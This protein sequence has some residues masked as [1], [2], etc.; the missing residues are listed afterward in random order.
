MGKLRYTVG[1]FFI[2][3][4]MTTVFMP[5]QLIVPFPG[6]V[7]PYY[8]NPVL[9]EDTPIPELMINLS[10]E[11]GLPVDVFIAHDPQLEGP[12]HFV[13]K[14]P[15][16]NDSAIE[17]LPYILN[18]PRHL[19]EGTI[20]TLFQS[21]LQLV[22]HHETGSTTFTD[23]GAKIAN[24]SHPAMAA[25][26]VGLRTALN[27][28]YATDAESR[29]IVPYLTPLFQ[30]FLDDYDSTQFRNKA[31]IHQLAAF[32]AS[33]AVAKCRCI[34][35]AK[36]QL[37]LPALNMN[38]VIYGVMSQKVATHLNLQ[39]HLRKEQ[40]LAQFHLFLNDFRS[41]QSVVNRFESVSSYLEYLIVSEFEQWMRALVSQPDLFRDAS[42]IKSVYEKIREMTQKY[43]YFPDNISAQTFELFQQNLAVFRR[44]LFFILVGLFG[45][46]EKINMSL[47]T[48]KDI[49][50]LRMGQLLRIL[51]LQPE[52]S[53]FSVGMLPLVAGASILQLSSSSLFG[54]GSLVTSLA[55]WGIG[56]FSLNSARK[57]QID[58]FTLDWLM[59]YVNADMPQDV[60]ALRLREQL[61]ILLGASMPLAGILGQNIWMQSPLSASTLVFAFA[62]L[63][64]TVGFVR[65][66]RVEKALLSLLYRKSKT[67]LPPNSS[68]NNGSGSKGQQKDDVDHEVFPDN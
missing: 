38:A 52:R 18:N 12:I 58:V 7:L 3:N 9:V 63:S 1:P 59:K 19:T 68:S 32:M 17:A 53:F 37:N 62:A 20:K 24:K 2:L 6:V 49:P 28:L 16:L 11:S 13:L 66:K 50:F 46:E 48:D 22:L 14:R 10:S 23:L 44:S 27:S 21:A 65:H 15:T 60:Q 64:A 43:G 36:M 42:K 26:I 57:S 4:S 8:A 51:L 29:L 39:T 31:S 33:I 67:V 47:L 30:G 25:F 40:K 35:S 56:L 41:P 55:T 45:S 5:N 34:K 54:N 61:K